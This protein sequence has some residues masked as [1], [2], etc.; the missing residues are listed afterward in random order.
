[1][2]LAF[3]WLGNDNVVLVWFRSLVVGFLAGF[4]LTWGIA[5]LFCVLIL[6]LGLFCTWFAIV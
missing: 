2:G 5:L 4:V 3:D 1:M 6:D